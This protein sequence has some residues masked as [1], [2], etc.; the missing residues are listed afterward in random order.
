MY[1]LET[2]VC[3]VAA[4]KLLEVS[5]AVCHLDRFELVDSTDRA[6]RLYPAAIETRGDAVDLVKRVVAVFLRP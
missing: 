1:I 6:H 5:G 2:A 3:G 4:M